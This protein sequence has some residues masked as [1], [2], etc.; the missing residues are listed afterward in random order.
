MT[1]REEAPMVTSIE[2]ARR[3]VQSAV[4]DVV[5]CAEADDVGSFVEFDATLWTRMLALG[6]ALVLL[7]LLKH[8]ARPRPMRYQHEGTDY[9]LGE[10]KTKAIGTRYGKVRFRR[11]VGRPA[12]NPKGKCDAVVDRELGLCGGFGLEVV[13]TLGYLAAQ[14]SFASARKTYRRFYEWA[15]SPRALLRMVD[16]VGSKAR[17]FL[18]QASVP[19]DDG[20]VLFVQVDGKAAPMITSGEY[21]KRRK[22]HK[23]KGRNKRHSRRRN[24]APLT[25]R[26][27]TKGKKSKNG[28][29]AV[30][31]A[32]YTLRRT[33]NGLEG[34]IN[35]R[36]YAT[37]KSHEELFVW[38]RHEAEKRGYGFKTTVFLGDGCE[39]LWRFKAI[40]FPD[41]IECIDWCHVVEKLWKAGECV[42]PEGSDELRKW[43]GKQ[44]AQLRRGAA[45]AVIDTL[46]DLLAAVP[47]TGP[48]NKGKR[49][50]LQK[51]I[52]Y[53]ETHLSRMQ[54]DQMRAKDYDIGTGIIEGAIRHL[55]AYR[56]DGPGMRWSR[57]RSERVLH[58]RCILING[59]W[60]EFE[61]YL[62]R[63]RGLTLAAKP[64]ATETYDAVPNKK[65]A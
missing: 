47:P 45:Q 44:A 20:E 63:K 52:S 40:Y 38:L 27:R 7:F 3:D 16:A 26:R 14:M 54:Y 1:R 48:G 58:L 17:E 55:M 28:K 53:Y 57:Q 62:A 33:P 30:V 32:I 4:R 15:P 19:E 22:S 50:R 10:K 41:A 24:R 34:P 9:V 42:Y 11:V 51:T 39:H 35:K 37:F 65:A 2:Q 49:K 56:L 43:I 59:Q 8:A 25:L 23:R 29:V 31:G 36:V 21:R 6:R 18:E 61:R 12:G 46:K 5:Q 64:E 13:L 60:E